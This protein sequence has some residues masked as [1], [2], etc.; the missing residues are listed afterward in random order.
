MSHAAVRY[1]EAKRSVD[2]RALAPGPI[3]TI[4]ASL[5]PEPRILEAGCGTGTMVPRLV[6]WGVDAGTYLGVDRDRTVI[7][8]ARYLRAR[9]L[10]YGGREVVETADGFRVGDLAVAFERGDAMGAFAEGRVQ[11][12]SERP[13]DGADLF[14]ASCF[15][16]LVPVTSL[17]E[18]AES[19]LGPGA[20]AYFPLSFDGGTIF[21]PDHPADP[22]VE[23]AYHEAIAERTGRDPH[24][25][26]H[27]AATLQDR[28]G[29]VL[30][31]AAADWVVRP[32]GGEYPADERYFLARILEFV[33]DTVADG[34]TPV[35]EL[36]DWL[37]TRRAQLAAGD[38]IYVAHQYD[39]LYR[40]P[41][42]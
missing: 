32:V 16:D 26:R 38:L 22:Q 4:L 11:S 5:P 10:R 40:L 24:A 36:D 8:V 7:D 27:L 31:M 13:D 34:E 35:P 41:E 2:D 1:L 19:A 28:P 14:V 9:E 25:G 37:R 33:E 3:E 12:R 39:I 21:Q 6:E 18:T 42:R 17:V 15:A 29:A 30:D 20:L 23:A